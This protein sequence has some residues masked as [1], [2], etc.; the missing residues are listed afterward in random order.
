MIDL[1]WVKKHLDYYATQAKMSAMRCNFLTTAVFTAFM[2]SAIGGESVLAGPTVVEQRRYVAVH[3]GADIDK[4]RVSD[5]SLGAWDQ[6]ASASNQAGRVTGSGT[7][8]QISNVNADGIT[9]L[10][11]GSASQALSRGRS[12][13]PERY[14]QVNSF[15]D[16]SL[17]LDRVYRYEITP[18]SGFSP[19]NS[20][21]SPVQGI[22][23][24]WSVSTASYKNRFTNG[25]SAGVLR[26]DG[27][28]G[29]LFQTRN[30]RNIITGGEI[31]PGLIRFQ[32]ELVGRAVASTEN[33]Y[34]NFNIG[35]SLLLRPRQSGNENVGGGSEVIPL[36]PA[37]LAA[38]IPLAGV[39]VATHKRR[40]SR[41]TFR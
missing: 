9:F 33:A 20:I 29:G 19:S 18:W 30:S 5:I 14:I 26:A 4:I 10:V 38:L 17:N 6:V 36:P 32:A 2:A 39:I 40:K 3:T 41:R 25:G 27:R 12:Q 37:V 13:T 8:R 16:V 1:N 21:G 31:G 15:I 24:Q 28:A 34:L 7:L 22:T 35:S 23:G 11:T